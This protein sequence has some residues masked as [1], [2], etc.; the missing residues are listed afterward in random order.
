MNKF[1]KTAAICAII[2]AFTTFLLWL[3]PK[4][5]SDVSSG[6]AGALLAVNPFYTGRLWVNFIHIFFALVGYLG[7]AFIIFKRAGGIAFSGFMWFLLWGFTEL[8]GVSVLIFAVNGSWRH[9]YLKAGEA[10]QVLLKQQ[11]DFFMEIWDAMFF[12]LLVFFL[13]GTLFYGVALW[14]GRGLEKLLSFLFLLGVPLTIFITVS[15]YGGPSWPGVI[16]SLAYPVL[17]PLNRAV[18]GAWI[19]KESIETK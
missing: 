3:L 5:Y 18:L 11:I 14:Q 13:L 8:L 17:Q 2:T 6:Q 15:G 7:A 19:W 4:F 10:R 1:L 9:D 16:A 12:L